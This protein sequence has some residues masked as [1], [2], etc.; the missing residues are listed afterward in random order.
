MVI[1]SLQNDELEPLEFKMLDIP[2]TDC[3]ES[4]A[5]KALLFTSL[6]HLLGKLQLKHPLSHSVPSGIHTHGLTR[7]LLQG[8]PF[9]GYE[10]L[11]KR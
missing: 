2:D 8:L 9:P 3:A 6:L 7:W 5:D 1:P 10:M 4:Q 11:L